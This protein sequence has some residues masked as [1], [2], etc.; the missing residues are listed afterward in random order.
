MRFLALTVSLAVALAACGKDDHD[1]HDHDDGNGCGHEEHEARHGGHLIEF[2][3]HEGHVEVKIDHDAGTV[4][5]WV[6]DDE[7]N[8]LALDGAPVMNFTGADGPVQVEGKGSGA[9]WTFTHGALKGEPENARF[10]L[11][12]NGKPYTPKWEHAHE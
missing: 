12:A 10:K 9:S 7:M 1:D 3:S 6:Y 5:M 11:V 8:D 2:G 4:T